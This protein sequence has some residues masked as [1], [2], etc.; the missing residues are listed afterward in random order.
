MRS[1]MRMLPLLAV[2]KEQNSIVSRNRNAF[3]FWKAA[4]QFRPIVVWFNL[5]YKLG[6]FSFSTARATDVYAAIIQEIKLDLTALDPISAVA[7]TQ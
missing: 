4:Y 7:F 3:P 5:F 6:S 2:G 1:A